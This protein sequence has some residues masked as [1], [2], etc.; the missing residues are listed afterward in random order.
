MSEW[1]D[2]QVKI[3]TV[4]VLSMKEELESLKQ[5][6][7]IASIEILKSLAFWAV[8]SMEY[9]VWRHITCRGVLAPRGMH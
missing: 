2:K 6:S 1:L 7:N 9:G 5:P 3:G 4:K 8:R